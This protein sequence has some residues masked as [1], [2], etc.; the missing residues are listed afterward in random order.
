MVSYLLDTSILIDLLRKKPQA[1][2]FLEKHPEDKFITSSICEAEVWEDVYREEKI[3]FER[4]RKAV[5]DLLESLYQI[6]PFDR[7]Q[8]QIAGQIRSRLS[9]KGEDIGDLDVLIAATAIGSEAILL[10]HNIKHFSRIKNLQFQLI[11]S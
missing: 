3:D 5:A 11:K 4:R 10:T 9:I 6:I 8:A 2:K 1:V 7:K